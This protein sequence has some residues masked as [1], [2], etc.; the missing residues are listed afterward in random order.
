M[1][2]T[3]CRMKFLNLLSVKL[4]NK[5][6]QECKQGEMGTI[7]VKYVLTLIRNVDTTA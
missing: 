3:S 4:L 7:A 5:N 1:I 2:P 6:K